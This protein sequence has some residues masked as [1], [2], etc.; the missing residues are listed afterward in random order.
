MKKHNTPFD[1]K[2]YHFKYE[3]IPNFISSTGNANL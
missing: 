2:S 3:L 1:L